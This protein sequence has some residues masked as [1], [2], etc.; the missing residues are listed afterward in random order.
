MTRRR[1]PLAVRKKGICLS[2]REK[3]RIK[4]RLLL[5]GRISRVAEEEGASLTTV[6][7]LARI[8]EAERP[9]ETPR[10]V[11][12]PAD[13]RR[14]H[15]TELLKPDRPEPMRVAKAVWGERLVHGSDCLRLNGSPINFIALMRRTNEWLASEGLPV[16]RAF[17]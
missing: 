8:V 13:C 4:A 11:H 7:K 12:H 9:P 16:M 10:I 6:Y 14:A 5:G 1:P 15:L 17:E 3:N 2:T